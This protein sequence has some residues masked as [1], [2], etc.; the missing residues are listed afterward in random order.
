MQQPLVDPDQLL[1]IEHELLPRLWAVAR[2]ERFWELHSASLLIH[3][4]R[5]L[6]GITEVQKWLS[7]ELD[8]P[9][10]ALTFL[11]TMLN[12]S[13]ISGGRGTRTVYTLLAAHLEKFVDL[14]KLYESAGR[15]AKD[16]LGKAAVKQLRTALNLKTDGK[17]YEEIY[18]L[19]QDEHG[20][21]LYD[22]SDTRI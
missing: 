9:I 3:R 1:A 17:L 4:L 10:A 14:E 20:K 12:E 22:E 11:H 13:H 8:K 6:A 16:E 7:V 2:T 15:A 5:D 18:V 19:S 21:Y